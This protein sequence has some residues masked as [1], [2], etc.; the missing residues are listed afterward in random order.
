M[1]GGKMGVRGGGSTSSWMGG[2]NG[3]C[4]LFDG[5]M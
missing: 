1:G 5:D 2:V 3:A 4:D